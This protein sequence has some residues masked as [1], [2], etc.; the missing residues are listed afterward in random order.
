MSNPFSRLAKKGETLFCEAWKAASRPLT[1]F[2]PADPC[3]N[4]LCPAGIF[5]LAKLPCGI[6]V[7]VKA[8]DLAGDKAEALRRMGIREGSRISLVSSHDPMLVV[9]E[10]TRIALSHR[11][12]RH[13]KVEATL[14]SIA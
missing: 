3:K 7:I 5:A 6:C 9:V 8:L 1:A 10:N 2:A 4:P 14:P 11:L 13:V 12:A